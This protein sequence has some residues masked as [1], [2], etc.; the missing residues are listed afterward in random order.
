MEAS[1]VVEELTT[2]I[3]TIQNE[4]NLVLQQSLQGPPGPQGPA[5]LQGPAGPAGQ[6]GPVGATG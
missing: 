4:L 6:G 1:A 5:G 3:R 2:A